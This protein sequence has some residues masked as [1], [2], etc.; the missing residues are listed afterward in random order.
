[1]VKKLIL[2]FIPVAIISSCLYFSITAYLNYRENYVEVYVASHNIFQRKCIDEKDL[3]LRVIPY[4]Y[5]SNDI[6]VEKDEMLGKYVKLSY[7][8]P[9]GSF[10][11]KTALEDDIKDLSHTLL[12]DGEVNYDIYTSEVKVN[13]RSLGLGMYV[14]LYLT[15]GNNR[16]KPISGVLIENARITG[17]YDNQGMAIGDYDN[18]SRISII[19]IAINKDYVTFLNK[20][21][22]V[23]NINVIV[24][25]NT[26][27]LDKKCIL[28]EESE[29]FMYLQ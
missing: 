14:D 23:G 4:Q 16:E 18:E 8:I 17:L 5:L 26:Y 25:N 6:Y 21:L 9:K 12:K 22:L 2:I 24:N 11:Y 29:V 15:I 13:P 27:E 3:E 1:M 28:H 7:S 20:A 10:I 19:S